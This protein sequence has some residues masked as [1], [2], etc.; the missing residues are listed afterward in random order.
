MDQQLDKCYLTTICIG[1]QYVTMV[2]D[3]QQMF[4][5]YDSGLNVT[6]MSFGFTKALGLWILYN[7]T[8]R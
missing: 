6:I 8:Q 4:R 2:V 3:N 5:H 1:G 7:E